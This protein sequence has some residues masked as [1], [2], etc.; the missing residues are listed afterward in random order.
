MTIYTYIIE[1]D[2]GFAPNPFHGVCT[3]ACCKP[4]IRKHAKEGDYIVGMGSVKPGLQGHVCYW[5]HVDKIL[6]FDQYWADARF[7][8]K[9]PLMHGSRYLAF[10]DNIYH[11]SA[12]GKSFIQED[13]YH[14]ASAH[15]ASHS[16]L[17]R[18]TGST[19]RVL[20]STEFAY[21]GRNGKLVP[22][23]L[24]EFVHRGPGHSCRF[25]KESQAS[26]LAWLLSHADRGLCGE[27]AGWQ[28]LDKKRKLPKRTNRRA[29]LR[30]A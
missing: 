23:E 19:H 11:L 17:A 7:R 27:P 4:K 6:T 26:F 20:T 3:L 8:R 9:R 10:G 21:W 15:Q 24:S 16:N 25:S 14:S 2:L 13:S 5:M 1:H 30:A 18:D 29:D 12:D 28:F 22:A